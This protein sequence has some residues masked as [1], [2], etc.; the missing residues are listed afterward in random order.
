MA[1]Q[2]TPQRLQRRSVATPF[3]LV[4]AGLLALLPAGCGP[5]L[6]VQ[7]NDQPDVPSPQPIGA[8]GVAAVDMANPRG[9]A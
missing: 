5:A 2:Q 6:Q 9:L 8:A 3:L 7:A 4:V 1:M